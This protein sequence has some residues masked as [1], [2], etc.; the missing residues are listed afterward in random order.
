MKKRSEI[1]WRL[2]VTISILI[3]IVFGIYCGLEV[4]RLALFSLWFQIFV[5]FTFTTIG[6]SFGIM[7]LILAV[8]CWDFIAWLTAWLIEG[9]KKMTRGWK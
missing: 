2:L 3:G 7:L 1:T 5:I 9:V 6:I 4:A 8:F